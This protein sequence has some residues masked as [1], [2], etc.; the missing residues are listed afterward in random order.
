MFALEPARQIGVARLHGIEYCPVHGDPLPACLLGA[1]EI[2]QPS[3]S[4]G[5]SGIN[6]LLE[7][8][9]DNQD[10]RRLRKQRAELIAEFAELLLRLGFG[11][12]GERRVHLLKVPGAGAR[13]DQVGESRLNDHPGFHYVNGAGATAWRGVFELDLGARRIHECAAPHASNDLPFAFQALDVTS[14][15][16]PRDIESPGQVAFGREAIAGFV[17]PPRNRVPQ[18][19][20]DL[21]FNA[22]VLHPFNRGVSG[23]VASDLGEIGTVV[24]NAG[25]THP[26]SRM[27]D[28][29]DEDFRRV[30]DVNFTALHNTATLIMPRMKA[31]GIGGA[32]VNISSTAA[33]RPGMA[34]TCYAAKKA[35]VIAATQGMAMELSAHNIRVNAVAPGL[36]KAGLLTRFTG[37]G[38]ASEARLK[39]GGTVPLG[40]LCQPEDVAN[41]VSFLVGPDAAFITGHC[42]PVDGGCL[43]GIFSAAARPV[44]AGNR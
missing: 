1:V 21:R 34:V 7:E 35:A 40:R 31:A 36:A 11:H 15:V 43:A 20:I 6:D 3:P 19:A 28:V 18:A 16:A 27:E 9:D 26:R 23:A 39:F 32:I 41:A 4:G 42:L 14:H 12:L 30:I 29:S 44:G 13:D 38:D 24:N 2:L 37:T 22:V 33:I 5:N 17:Q 8:V 10:S 25:Y